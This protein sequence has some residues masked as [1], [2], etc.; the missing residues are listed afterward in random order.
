MKKIAAVL[1]TALVL[2]ASGCD[3]EVT[4]TPDAPGGSAPQ[5]EQGQEQRTARIGDTI[6]LEGSD[7]EL[8]VAVTVL[9]VMNTKSTDSFISPEDGNRF[10]AVRL[11]LENVG[12]QVY[13]DSPVN[14][15]KLIDA[16]D[17]Q[18]DTVLVTGVAAGPLLDSVKLGPGKRRQGVV[19]FSIPKK[20]KPVG[21]QFA[22]DSGF[23][24]QTGEW[25][26]G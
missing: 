24:P 18:H 12:S 4:T 7:E 9:K 25:E 6:T 5:Q 3:T 1:V 16:G 13:D 11:R 19:V 26:L 21:F 10:V 14:G 23:A 20:A 8:K 15:A 17:Q 2:G 22:L